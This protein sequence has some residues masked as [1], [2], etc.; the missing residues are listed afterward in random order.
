M[1]GFKIEGIHAFV[2]VDPVS[3][4]EGVMGA[5]LDGTMYPLVSADPTRFHIYKKLAEDISRVTGQK[6]RVIR[7][8]NRVDV[9]DEILKG[10]TA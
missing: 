5:N 9:T 8:D 3:G 7:F 6:Y 10:S 4:D 2:A 1:S